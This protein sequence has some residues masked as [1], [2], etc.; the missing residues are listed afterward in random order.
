MRIGA[1]GMSPYIYNTNMLSSLSM[2][3]I[4]AIP[5]DVTSQQLDY[6]DLVSDDFENI[7]P[8]SKGQSGNF[9]DILM[10]QMSMSRYHQ[11]KVMPDILLVVEE[12]SE[13]G[14]E[15]MADEMQNLTKPQELEVV[16]GQ[17]EDPILT[18]EAPEEAMQQNATGE[19]TTGTGFSQFRMNQA[20]QAY[21]MSM[22]IA[23]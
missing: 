8:L 3:R 21:N 14:I 1:V 17:Q 9:M 20:I 10:S 15:D 16:S 7:N 11:A 22:G 23:S 19:D 12:D 13:L 5:D 2:N 18:V 6:T 4:S